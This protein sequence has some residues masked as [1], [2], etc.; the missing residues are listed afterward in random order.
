MS[1]DDDSLK[2]MTA[3]EWRELGFFT[4]VMTIVKRGS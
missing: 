4:I 1:P 3:E 2:E